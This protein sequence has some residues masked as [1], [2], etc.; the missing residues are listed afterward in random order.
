MFVVV[1]VGDNWG[2]LDSFG[3]SVESDRPSK[4]VVAELDN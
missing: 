1:V 2:S 3:L 4:L